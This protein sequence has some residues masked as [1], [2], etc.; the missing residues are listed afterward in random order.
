MSFWT[1]LGN[2]VTGNDAD[3]LARADMTAATAEYLRN[4]ASASAVPTSDK[5]GN[6]VLII[7]VVGA[8]VVTGAVAF[9]MLKKKSK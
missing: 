2:R 9:F 5:G 3:S 6:Q 7:S 4:A 8:L 1:D